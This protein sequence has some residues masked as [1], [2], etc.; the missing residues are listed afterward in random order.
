[1]P[2]VDTTL[3]AEADAP[4]TRKQLDVLLRDL[5][6]SA[7]GLEPREA[8]RRLSVY[9]PNVLPRPRRTTWPR[10]LARQVLHPLAV[11]LFAAAVLAL[12]AG[13]PL[14][15][16]AILAVI[17][18]N[19]VVA[20]V[21][22]TQAARAVQA[23]AKY[24]PLQAR[25]VRAGEAQMVPASAVVPGDVLLVDEGVRVSADARLMDGAVEIDLS[26]LTGESAPVLRSA[27]E[28]DTVDRLVDAPDA[29][30]SGTNCT[31]GRAHAVVFATGAHTELGR[32]AALSQRHHARESPLERQVRYG[33]WVIAAV[34]VAMGVVFLP[35]GLLAGLTL[36]DA[37]I[38]AVGLLV[39]NVPEGLLPT[40]TLALAIGVRKLA[41]AGALVK[42]LSAVETLGSTTVICTDK[43][44]TLTLNRMRVTGVW[45]GG[46]TR[47]SLP[48]QADGSAWRTLAEVMADC[49]EPM[50]ADPMECALRDS[51][52][53]IG[54]VA[55]P[56][57]AAF[58]FD[59]RR[60][61]MSVVTDRG[62][63][64]HVRVKGAPEAVLPLCAEWLAHDGVQP[65]TAT[66]ARHVTD[67]VDCFAAHGWRVLAL[68][69]RPTA[70]VPTT[71]AQAES[72]LCLLGLVALVDPPRPEVPG[73]VDDC[74]R[75]GIRIHVV[76]GD[77]VR[78]ATEV[79][80]Q[81]GIHATKAVTGLELDAM[82][83]A[84]LDR[85]LAGPDEIVFARATPENKLR[86]AEAL[87]H[88]GHVVAMT[89]DGVNDAPALHQADIGVAMGRSGTDVAREAAT[90]VLTDDNF[91]TI[92][93]AI[94]EGRRAYANL[95]KF[96]LYIF[97]HAI[98]E[99]VPFAVFV[100]TAGAVPIPLSV[101]QIL[102]ID[103][104]TDTLPAQALGR[105]IAEP[106]L[107]DR[108]PR[109][110]RERLIT[111]DILA[112]AWLLMGTLSAALTM[113]L[114]LAV[115]VRAG[116]H[117]GAAVGP[118]T[119]LHDAYRQ[120]TTITFAGIVA[121]QIGT[122]FA[123][124]TER[125]SLR[126]I[127]LL[128]NKLLIAAIGGEIAFAAALIYVP[129]LQPV[130]GTAPPP[131]WAVALLPVC[132]AVVWTADEL[133][134]LL[135]RSVRSRPLSGG[136]TPSHGRSSAVVA[137]DEPVHPEMPR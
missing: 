10:A 25:V 130:F 29:V 51:A 58:P 59:S 75:A 109:P 6:T 96:V 17:V 21:Q 57:V 110:R 128:S 16:W 23:L 84:D 94:R 38:F 108:R 87:Q 116:W 127:G 102:A 47:D 80:R 123:A 4:P 134:R 28:P 103:L 5:G 62:A 133:Y 121:C 117:P 42:R 100:L 18:I 112:R 82:N 129:A 63:G 40:I 99:V 37:V 30:F 124:R 91:A 3:S 73:A 95:R 114:Y 135:R 52:R 66:A 126:S 24:L 111:S 98:P 86:I 2:Y 131:A 65:L 69:T 54:V 97:T 85:M 27:D 31:S 78:T 125:A 132:S 105:E 55:E 89:G 101:M 34:A 93:T 60:R 1:M 8:D 88:E 41:K 81:V 61:R 45:S 119:P 106:G 74:H 67:A 56:A 43:T 64:L 90:M 76:T 12:V 71:A 113:A 13:T 33:A 15:C 115:L 72:R 137:P 50:S 122:A 92:V 36:A 118:G 14:L 48:E 22:E 70:T 32:I 19:A 107:M 44:G 77:H 46:S 39:A 68:A 11:L 136:R 35:F 9:G 104:G 79:A 120:A 83:D 7:D 53:T 26:A 20:F 49:R